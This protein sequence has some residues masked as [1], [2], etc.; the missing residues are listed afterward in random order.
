MHM[1]KTK[2]QE[3][4]QLAGNVYEK[5]TRYPNEFS[6]EYG[7]SVLS[8]ALEEATVIM[9]MEEVRGGMVVSVPTVGFGLLSGQPILALGRGYTSSTH[10]NHRHRSTDSCR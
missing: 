3:F 5:I 6:L 2:R 7:V 8:K 9:G 1:K 4:E 10:Q